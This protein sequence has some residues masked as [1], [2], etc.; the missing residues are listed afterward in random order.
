MN[1]IILITGISVANAIILILVIYNL[2]KHIFKLEYE[3]F[4]LENSLVELK[5]KFLNANKLL[6]DHISSDKPKPNTELL[7]M[8]KEMFQLATVLMTPDLDQFKPEDKNI[9]KMTL[10]EQLEY[11]ISI[12]DFEMAKIIQSKIDNQ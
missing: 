11:Y 12:E 9:D 8:A 3:L 5:Q 4:K 2:K 10:Q 1:T 6:M 7:D